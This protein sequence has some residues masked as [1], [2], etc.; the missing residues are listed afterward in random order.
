[1]KKNLL[2]AIMAIV[3]LIFSSCNRN[4]PQL[5]PVRDT[6]P[7]D[8]TWWS[9]TTIT[10]ESGTVIESSRFPLELFHELGDRGDTAAQHRIFKKHL[11]DLTINV[12]SHYPRIATHK[13]I[14]F[15]LATGH[16]SDIESGDGNSYSG[17]VKN[18]LIIVLDDPT[19]HK[20]LFLTCGNGMM[21]ETNMNQF[22]S[23]IDWGTAIPW[24]IEI[25]EG[26]SLA[27]HWPDLDVWADLAEKLGVPIVNERGELV[28]YTDYRY[29]L[30]SYISLL[31][32]GD[33][34]NLLELTVKDSE[35]KLVDAAYAETRYYIHKRGKSPKQTTNPIK[36]PQKG[37]QGKRR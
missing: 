15:Y 23:C 5:N 35:G 17:P 33:V 13:N 3:A 27:S 28:P 1:M 32:T 7:V 25:K 31:W 24:E 22:D 2:L 20:T 37:K 8:T 11:R 21:S 36:K 12:V 19:V 16:A 6:K 34:I 9:G 29:H 14:H 10:T 18:E 26:E 4:Q 30:G